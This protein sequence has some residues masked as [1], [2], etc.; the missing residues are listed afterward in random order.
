MERKNLAKCIASN[1]VTA[2]PTRSSKTYLYSPKTVQNPNHRFPIEQQQKTAL[3]SLTAKYV[4]QSYTAQGQEGT[5]KPH[6]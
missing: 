2:F 1:T 3:T 6:M 5:K 4:R